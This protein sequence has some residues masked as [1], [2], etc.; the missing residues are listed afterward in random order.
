MTPEKRV[1]RHLAIVTDQTV[2]AVLPLLGP[3]RSPGTLARAMDH[4]FAYDEQTKRALVE[5]LARDPRCLPVCA[6]GCAFCCHQSVFAAV[7]EIL[8]AAEHLRRTLRPAALAALTA[9]I[10]RTASAVADLSQAERAQSKTPCPLL[11]DETQACGAYEARPLACRA[12]NSCDAGVCERAFDAA[13]THWDV[14]VDLFQL[15]VSRNVRAGLMAAAFAAGLD[16]GPYELSVGLAIALTVEDAAARW[17]LGEP[18]FAPA[19]TA[20]GRSRRA[21]WRASFAET[22]RDVAERAP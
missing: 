10:V 16:P 6:P 2:G 8:H 15:T 20:I 21:G 5:A 14:P 12:Y 7:P 1:E 13:L 9:R 4:T 18:V 3:G 22:A 11:D 19:E 17:L